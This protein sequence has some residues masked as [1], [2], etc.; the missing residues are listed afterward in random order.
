M[1]WFYAGGPNECEHGYA[2]GI[3]CP[4]CEGV[5]GTH[6]EARGLFRHYVAG[7]DFDTLDRYVDYN[8]RMQRELSLLKRRLNGLELKLMGAKALAYDSRVMPDIT[9]AGHRIVVYLTKAIEGRRAEKSLVAEAARRRE[10]ADAAERAAEDL[11]TCI[12]YGQE[13]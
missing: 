10:E 6:E 7:S 9:D 13:P 12:K 5:A 1:D 4:K 2:E 11:L 3:P 8:V